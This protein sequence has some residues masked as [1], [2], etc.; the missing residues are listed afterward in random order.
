M[1]RNNGYYWIKPKNREWIISYAY[2]GL[3]KNLGKD[4]A[5]EWFSDNELDSIDE[6]E[7]NKNESI[8]N[9]VI[10]ISIIFKNNELYDVYMKLDELQ[11]TG[12]LTDLAKLFNKLR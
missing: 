1:K 8:D 7:I 9:S 6:N 11:K 3:F 10:G 2:H 5:I 12:F 4:N